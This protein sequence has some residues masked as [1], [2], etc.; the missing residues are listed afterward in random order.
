MM[1]VEGL[2]CQEFHPIQNF[3]FVQPLLSFYQQ[4]ND[5]II[6]EAKHLMGISDLDEITS[7]IQGSW[8]SFYLLES[9]QINQKSHETAPLLTQMIQR[10]TSLMTCS[11]GYAYISILGPYS[12]ITPHCGPCNIKLRCHLPLIVPSDECTIRVGSITKQF[13]Q[14][15]LLIFDDSIEHEVRNDSSSS[16]VVL[17]FDIWHPDLTSEEINSFKTYFK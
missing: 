9:G 3:D 6:M 12:H 15:E 1:F 5:A 16:R 14:G 2:T 13:Q 8:K 10:V 17:L 7:S 4:H 11:F